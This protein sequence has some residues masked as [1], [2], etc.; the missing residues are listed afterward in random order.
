MNITKIFSYFLRSL[1]F[2]VVIFTD[3]DSCDSFRYIAEILQNH[4]R[5]FSWLKTRNKNIISVNS[6][7]VIIRNTIF[8]MCFVKC[9]NNCNK[10]KLRIIFKC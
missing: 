7:S 4:L 9:S 3:T 2:I 8:S 6:Q 5:T 10:N 1:M